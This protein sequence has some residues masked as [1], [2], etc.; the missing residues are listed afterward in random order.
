MAHTAL[1]HCTS[2]WRHATQIS[3]CCSRVARPHAATDHDAAGK[4]EQGPYSTSS[5]YSPAE[6]TQLQQM[7]KLAPDA[8]LFADA[9][10]SQAALSLADLQSMWGS[11]AERPERTPSSDAGGGAQA[12]PT[13]AGTTASEL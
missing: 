3:L 8:M 12:R 1:W 13:A 7:G 9:K 11:Q 10:C 6:I 4:F 5:P 2:V